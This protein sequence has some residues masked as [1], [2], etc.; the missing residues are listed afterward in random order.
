MRLATGEDPKKVGQDMFNRATIGLG[1][2]QAAG[3]GTGANPIEGLQQSN[4]AAARAMGI[5]GGD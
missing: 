3:S 5:G 1:V 2:A 4:A